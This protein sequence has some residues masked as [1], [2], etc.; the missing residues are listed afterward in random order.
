MNNWE[1]IAKL[2]AEERMGTIEG[3][4]RHTIARRMKRIGARWSPAGT[5]H[6]ARLL[7]A[8]SN[9]ELTRY[10]DNYRA[11]DRDRLARVMPESAINSKDGT[12]R[13]DWSKW[14]AAEVPALYGPEADKMWIKYVLKQ[15]A[16]FNAMT[17]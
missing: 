7:A 16:R 6:M 4:V 13:R 5:D 17:A 2:P 11:I 9:N 14:L 15:I 10:A 8:R 12:A 3:Q 1:G